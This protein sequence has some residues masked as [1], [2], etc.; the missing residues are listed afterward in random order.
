MAIV[1]IKQTDSTPIDDDSWT[2][3]YET[4]KFYNLGINNPV[5]YDFSG[6]TLKQGVQIA[7]GG[8]NYQVTSDETI[9]GTPSKYVRIT[10]VGVEALTAIAEYVP[11]LGGVTWN[12]TFNFYEDTSGNAMIFNHAE[13]VRLLNIT[14][15]KTVMG[16]FSEEAHIKYGF[17]NEASFKGVDSPAFINESGVQITANS[18]LGQGH[19]GTLGNLFITIDANNNTSDGKFVINKDDIL[20]TVL[21]TILENGHHILN[22][23][24]DDGKDLQVNGS[25]S[26]ETAIFE[27][28]A[29]PAFEELIGL[30]ITSNTGTGA[31]NLGTVGDFIVT[32]DSNDNSTTAKFIIN[33]NGIT[34]DEIFIV[35][36]DGE[37]NSYG[38]TSDT[39][40][41]FLNDNS[42]LNPLSIKSIN[43]REYTFEISSSSD[44]LMIL[45]NVGVGD[46]DLSVLG[47]VSIQNN[48][49][50][51]GEINPTT[52]PAG[53]TISR[54]T[55]GNTFIPRGV[56]I[57]ESFATILT[58]G[59]GG[60]VTIKVE[61]LV[62][63]TWYEMSSV[64]R[65]PGTGGLG[66]TK[67]I[68]T[69]N[70]V[71]STGSDLRINV[72]ITDL[73]GFT[74]EAGVFLFKT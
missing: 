37:I 57:I 8:S 68:T 30:Q 43:V 19:I 48:L 47:G 26:A 7:I 49:T 41:S 55:N 64:S 16:K 36:E 33:R 69:T 44:G 38:S 10:P 40:I 73:G 58:V 13:Q 35:N 6:N 29:S 62:N 66:T 53:S 67:E 52:T 46:F 12:E 2:K 20:G 11:S 63:G 51:G 3:L 25:M 65:T 27:G 34:G 4:D 9:T 17:I 24:F 22:S 39:F 5:D 70:L 28:V 59:S 50:V 23:S 56:Y 72:E 1:L 42:P 15:P 74:S 21:F 61:K 32:I 60:G 31:A 54:S 18:I 14:T 45:S 71:S